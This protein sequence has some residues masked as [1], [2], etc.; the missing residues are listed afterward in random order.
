MPSHPAMKFTS[1]TEIDTRITSISQ[2]DTKAKTKLLEDTSTLNTWVIDMG[3]NLSSRDQENY[4]RQV[5]SLQARL[6]EFT[7]SK[8]PK[9]KFTKRPGGGKATILDGQSSASSAASSPQ[10]IPPLIHR[11]DQRHL[12][13]SAPGTIDSDSDV[14]PIGR[15]PAATSV[16]RV[17]V[18]P[19]DHS[20]IADEV[21]K[22][23]DLPSSP[24]RPVTLDGLHKCVIRNWCNKK[25]PA[26]YLRK[27]RG[28]VIDGGWVEGSVFVEDVADS[29]I[30]VRGRQVRV[31][32]SKGL[33]LVIDVRSKPIIEDCENISVIELDREWIENVGIIIFFLSFLSRSNIILTCYLP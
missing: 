29:I 30:F 19:D 2:A 24:G 3:P 27:I 13:F 6:R 17:T 23:L 5:G 1:S 15:P 31:H 9:F 21:G 22:S 12:H 18:A 11:K 25:I 28:C 33:S 16:S 4:A 32:A 26:L 10:I 7:N 8:R 20:V 14:Q